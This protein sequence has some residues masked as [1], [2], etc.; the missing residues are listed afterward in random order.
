MLATIVEG[1]REAWSVWGRG[2]RERLWAR[3]PCPAWV[4]G[5]STSPLD[6]VHWAPAFL[7]TVLAALG[8]GSVHS[9]TH[10]AI[11]IRMASDDTCLVANLSVSCREVGAK[12][13]ALGIPSDA[14][15]QLGIDGYRTY[16]AIR[17]MVDSLRQ[18]GYKVD[19]V[20]FI[21]KPQT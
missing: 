4:P 6:S 13:H 10:D 7:L 12:L 19:K 20:G 9:Q 14:D 15:I 11:L 3:G 17:T 2:S 5:P 1:G 18:A 21:T 8:W 16:E